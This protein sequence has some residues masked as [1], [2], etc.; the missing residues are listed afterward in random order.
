[1]SSTKIEDLPDNKDTSSKIIQELNDDNISELSQEDIQPSAAPS[2]NVLVSS[3]SSSCDWDTIFLH[4]K[5]ASIV[6]ALVFIMSNPY[7]I[8]S[9]STL[10]YIKSLEP[11]SM[12]FNII[13][14]LIV[15]VLFFIIKYS[16][17]I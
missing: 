9:L 13:I 10:P 11:H 6:F 8:S 5:D 4:A 2:N 3:S 7:V 14:S 15:S 12:I 17:Y 1:M 16:L